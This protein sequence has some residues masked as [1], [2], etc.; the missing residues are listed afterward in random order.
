MHESTPRRPRRAEAS[1]YGVESL[2]PGPSEIAPFDQKE[3]KRLLRKIDLVILPFVALLYLL[4]FLYR[5]NIGNDRLSG[6]G[7]DLNME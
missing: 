5:A 7:E 2:S 4:R 6:L 3:T 1:A